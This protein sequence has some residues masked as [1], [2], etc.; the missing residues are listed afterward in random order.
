MKTILLATVCLL[1]AG[2]AMAERPRYNRAT[3]EYVS[4]EPDGYSESF[5]GFGVSGEYRV[6]PEVLVSASYVT[7]SDEI[8]GYDVDVS[9]FSIGGDYIIEVQHEV[10][11][12]VGAFLVRSEA[13][14]SG[15]SDSDSDDTEI[16][17]QAGVRKAID[18]LPMQ[19]EGGLTLVDGDISIGGSAACFFTDEVSAHLSIAF[20]DGESFGLG[21]SYW[22]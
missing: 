3:L 2:Q 22:F 9:A 18:Q 5:D 6:A 17:I 11:V 16:G 13:E 19:F 4:V 1:F 15:S 10:D 7:V 20:G 12:L 21:G 14:V 8:L